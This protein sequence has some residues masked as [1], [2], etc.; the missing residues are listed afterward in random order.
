MKKS[1][2]ISSLSKLTKDCDNYLGCFLLRLTQP[3]HGPSEE[4]RSPAHER[5]SSLK[6]VHRSPIFDH[7]LPIDR[8]WNKNVLT[9][10]ISFKIERKRKRKRENEIERK[11]EKKREKAHCM[12]ASIVVRENG[13]D[14]KINKIDC[15]DWVN[16]FCIRDRRKMAYAAINCIVCHW[17][18]RP[19]HALLRFTHFKLGR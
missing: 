7:L 6:A 17:H 13:I 2:S 19:L 14:L 8:R 12:N 18:F 5:C 9:Q 11:K 15:T 16:R 1:I 10:Y 4:S 3:D